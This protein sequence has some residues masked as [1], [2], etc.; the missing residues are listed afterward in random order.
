MKSATIAILFSITDF[1][2]LKQIGSPF[3]VL[4]FPGRDLVGWTGVP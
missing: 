1:S 2:S 3:E 4:L